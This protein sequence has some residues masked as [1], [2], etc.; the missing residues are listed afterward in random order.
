MFFCINQYFKIEI[1]EIFMRMMTIKY[2]S[3]DDFQTLFHQHMGY[4]L[5]PFTD[6]RNPFGIVHVHVSA[7]EKR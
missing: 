1:L 2:T 4:N 3:L 6:S 5:E 7:S